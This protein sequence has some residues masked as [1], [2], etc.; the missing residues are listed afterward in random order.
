MTRQ[1]RTAPKTAAERQRLERERNKRARDALI[2]LSGF[3][4]NGAHWEEL[5]LF[6]PHEIF[7]TVLLVTK[8]AIH[9]DDIINEWRLTLSPWQRARTAKILQQAN[10]LLP[11]CATCG[12]NLE[13]DGRG[14][15][16][17]CGCQHKTELRPTMT[18]TSDFLRKLAEGDGNNIERDLTNTPRLVLRNGKGKEICTVPEAH[19]D[20]LLEQGYLKRVNGKW[21]LNDAGK[22]AAKPK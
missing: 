19:F 7:G 5:R 13:Q 20:N 2:G 9:G 11:F 21:R 6:E 16:N 3:A 22:A 15:L 17:S 18:T 8:W 1:A 10:I 12:A 4:Q 14:T